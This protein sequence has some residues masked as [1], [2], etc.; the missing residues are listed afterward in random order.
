M[1]L[2]SSE[3]ADWQAVGRVVVDGAGP[4]SGCTGVMI[5]DHRILTASHCV[6]LTEGVSVSFLAGQFGA[7]I[8][9]RITP[10]TQARHPNAPEGPLSL[11]TIPFDT[12]QL[13]LRDAAPMRPLPLGPEPRVGE[14]LMLLAY[15]N[16]MGNIPRWHSC[17]VLATAPGL[18][19][20]DCAAQGGMSGAPLLRI[21]DAGTEVTAI[22]SA[23]AQG[24]S[25]AAIPDDWVISAP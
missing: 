10:D 16:G 22:L 18:A 2:T 11:E 4:N 15:S 14:T 19:I 6:P 13:T 1:P 21:T 23:T 9:A 5:S 3:R 7:D 12:A 25:Y 8:I 20:L 17:P 24:T